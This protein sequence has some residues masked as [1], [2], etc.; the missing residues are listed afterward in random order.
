MQHTICWIYNSET[1]AVTNSKSASA[2]A[3]S[4]WNSSMK[5]KLICSDAP[6]SK[7][8][9]TDSCRFKRVRSIDTGQWETTTR[10]HA[11]TS[12]RL[13]PQREEPSGPC[14]SRIHA[15]ANCPCRFD[16]LAK[17]LSGE[18]NLHLAARGLHGHWRPNPESSPSSCR[19]L[20]G[21][22]RWRL[23]WGRA[24]TN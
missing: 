22:P 7:R 8:R 24:G 3:V 9:A 21:R 4:D 10:W 11:F 14:R 13:Q 12:R 19:H 20:P 23:S 15:P 17:L 16:E 6:R 2:A 1:R 5:R 18:T